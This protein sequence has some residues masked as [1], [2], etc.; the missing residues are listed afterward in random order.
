MNFI[1]WNSKGAGNKNF[2]RH[3]IDMIQTY[4]PSIMAVVEPRISGATARKVLRSLRMPKSHVAE[5]EGFD[6]GICLSWEESILSVDV[7]FSS[8]QMVHAFVQKPGSDNFLLKILY[9]SPILENQRRLWS[10]L[11]NLDRSL[12]LPW[13]VM[14]DFNDVLNSS[15]K[16]GGLAPSI[17]RCMSLNSM[18]LSCRLLDLGFNGQSLT[19]FNKRKGSHPR[20][21]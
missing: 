7:L 17:G 12:N 8:S 1:L 3:A 16:R 20:A 2:R 4:K 14:G 6:G 13:V 18:I 19:C 9:D 10:L 15:Q 5:P 21:S 11:E